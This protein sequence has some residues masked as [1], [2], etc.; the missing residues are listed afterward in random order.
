[1][2]LLPNYTAS[3]IAR[4]VTGII[5]IRDEFSRRRRADAATVS[6]GNELLR[7]GSSP[8]VSVSDRTSG[9]DEPMGL[10]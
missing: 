6:A 2:Q 4:L 1:M 7:P 9:W 10:T 3:E 5:S 8:D